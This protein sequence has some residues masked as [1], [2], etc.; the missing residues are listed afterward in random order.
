MEQQHN[1]QPNSS[2]NIPDEYEISIIDI[3]RIIWKYKALVAVFVL[4]ITVATGVY[5]RRKP[6]AYQAQTIL[7][8]DPMW[9]HGKGIETAQYYQ[10]ARSSYFGKIVTDRLVSQGLINKN[11]DINKIVKLLNQSS[12]FTVSTKNNKADN[13]KKILS[14]WIAEYRKFVSGQIAK[15]LINSS[16]NQM[17]T[18][19]AEFTGVITSM[20]F[21]EKQQKA[22]ESKTQLR[23]KQFSFP[24]PTENLLAEKQVQL[25]E[26]KSKRQFNKNLISILSRKAEGKEIKPTSAENNN[27]LSAYADLLISLNDNLVIGEPVVIDRKSKA[28][29]LTIVAFVSSFA[30]ACMGV[31]FVDSIK[32]EMNK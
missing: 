7:Q 20:E 24:D 25:V 19:R 26:L 18:D 17:L 15:N 11:K 21:L 9:L 13:A 6:I 29:L 23:Q 28:L 5:V 16:K 1:Q 32:R 4:I 31:F 12:Q 3:V 8:S 27:T 14:I 10:L 2:F 22:S 30:I